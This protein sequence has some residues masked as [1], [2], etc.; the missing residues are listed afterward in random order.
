MSLKNDNFHRCEFFCILSGDDKL[1]DKKGNVLK[2]NSYINN[3][4]K[5]ITK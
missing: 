4:N 2:F 1:Q 5:K 3:E